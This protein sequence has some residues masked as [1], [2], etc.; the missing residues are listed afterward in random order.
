MNERNFPEIYYTLCEASSILDMPFV[1][2][3]YIQWSYGI[4]T[5][6]AGVEEP[7][8]VLNSGAVNLLLREELLFIIGM[9]W[10]I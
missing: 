1:P 8:I 4:N 10:D 7:I 5:M 2:K 3:L 6:T 9:S